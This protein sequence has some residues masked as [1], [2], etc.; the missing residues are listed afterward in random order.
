MPYIIIKV[1]ILKLKA[2]KIKKKYTIAL[3]TIY[4]IDLDHVIYA[5]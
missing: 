5:F 2:C 4:V 1:W 3:L